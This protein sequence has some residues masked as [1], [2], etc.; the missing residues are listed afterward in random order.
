MILN[1][2]KFELIKNK[3]MSL[4]NCNYIEYMYN[5]DKRRIDFIIQ[6]TKINFTIIINFYGDEIQQN[7]EYFFKKI[8]QAIDEELHNIIYKVK[9]ERR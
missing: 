6:Y 8:V 2:R 9:Y 4:L 3:L 5:V 1:M 7:D